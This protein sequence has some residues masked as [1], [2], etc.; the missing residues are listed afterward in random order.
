VIREHTL[1]WFRRFSAALFSA[2][3]KLVSS[4]LPRKP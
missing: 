2:L 1:I 3:K 4:F